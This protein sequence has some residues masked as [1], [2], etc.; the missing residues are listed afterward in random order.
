[1]GILFQREKCFSVNLNQNQTDRET[2]F[3]VVAMHMS[4]LFRYCNV[5][6]SREFFFHMNFARSGLKVICK[7]TSAIL[8]V[9]TPT[10]TSSSFAFAMKQISRQ[11]L[12][13][14]TRLNY[15]IDPGVF[16]YSSMFVSFAL[17]AY[18]FSSTI[19]YLQNIIGDAKSNVV[20]YTPL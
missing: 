11:S 20:K 10:K 9:S 19:G 3:Q 1:M 2:S 4:F 7:I 18:V 16:N 14:V 8:R 15:I 6:S 5:T 12:G 17:K 13:H